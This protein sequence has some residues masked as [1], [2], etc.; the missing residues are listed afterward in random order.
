M[1]PNTVVWELDEEGDRL[2]NG[3]GGDAL[4]SL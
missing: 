4:C 1:S 2:L 3:K